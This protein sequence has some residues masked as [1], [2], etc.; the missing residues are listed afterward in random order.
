[1]LDLKAMHENDRRKEF[2]L[3]LVIGVASWAIVVAGALAQTFPSKPV[4][5]IVAFPPGQATD[6]VARLLAEELTKVWDKQVVIDNRAGGNSIPGTVA[7]KAALADGYTIT[8]G[9]SSALAVNP[10]LYTSLPYDTAKDFT[11]VCG[12]FISPWVIVAHPSTPYNTLR[13]MVD[14]A[15]KNPNLLT[16]GYGATSLQLGAE[17]FKYRA[18]IEIVGVPYKGSGPATVD[19]VGGQIP[20]LV[21]TMAATLQFIKNGKMKALA[22]MTA[23]RAPLL[24]DLPTVAEQGYPDFEGS[25]WGGLVLPKR[26]PTGI[27]QKIGEDVRRIVSDPAVQHKMI[28]RGA[29][30]DPRGPQEWSKFVHDELLKWAQV[31]KRANVRAD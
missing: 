6:I 31:A 11:M 5:M 29:V 30:P 4:R 19:L 7:G 24:P 1:M 21:D 2:I 23:K 10:S 28:D 22:S 20:L 9:T 15:K 14:T 12:V 17:L 13:E 8:F 25:G 26:T 3:K 18:G 27:V 16:W